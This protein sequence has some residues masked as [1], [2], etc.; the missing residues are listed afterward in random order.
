VTTEESRLMVLM[1]RG[2][3]LRNSG[4]HTALL[5]QIEVARACERLHALPS[6][7]LAEDAYTLRRVMAL[8]GEMDRIKAT[9]NSK[10]G[11]NGR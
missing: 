2:F 10:A 8:L 7:V 11:S 5:S 4:Q 6:Q 1:A 9:R 3:K